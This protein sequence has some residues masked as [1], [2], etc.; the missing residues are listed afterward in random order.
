MKINF[1]TAAC[2]CLIAVA[3]YFKSIELKAALG[4]TLLQ[5][6]LYANNFFAFSLL[7]NGFSYDQ[8]DGDVLPVLDMGYFNMLQLKLIYV[9]RYLGRDQFLFDEYTKCVLNDIER[10][11]DSQFKANGWDFTT[12]NEMPVPSVSFKDVNSVAIYEKYVKRG[13]PFVVKHFPS[14]AVDTWSP[15]FFASTYGGHETM[16][17]N[18]TELAVLRMNMSDYVAS[19]REGNSNGVLYIRALSDIFDEFPVS[20]E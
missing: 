20:S 2:V 16:V 18:T 10:R 1:K 4:A 14:R 19:Q 12:F 15:E 7:G 17:I 8:S 9:S 3:F 5:G 11:L 6:F 13:I